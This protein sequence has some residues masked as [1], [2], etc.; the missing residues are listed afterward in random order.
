MAKGMGL[1]LGLGLADRGLRDG[2]DEGGEE[3]RDAEQEVDVIRC[4]ILG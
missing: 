2:G 4:F 1:E 3:G